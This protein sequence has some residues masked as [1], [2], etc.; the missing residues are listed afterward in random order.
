MEEGQVLRS[1][2]L[3]AEAEAAEEVEVE[4]HHTQ[5]QEQEV[6]VVG[7][8]QA[9]E[10]EV[11]AQLEEAEEE[12]A[13]LQ[14]EQPLLQLA[15][16]GEAPCYTLELEAVLGAEAEEALFHALEPCQRESR[17]HPQATAYHQHTEEEF[18][19]SQGTPVWVSLY[20]HPY[21]GEDSPYSLNP[22]SL[23]PAKHYGYSG[24]GRMGRL[25][26]REA[27]PKEEEL[28]EEELKDPPEEEEAPGVQGQKEPRVVLCLG[29]RATD[30]DQEEE[31]AGVVPGNW[32]S[33]ERNSVDHHPT[34]GQYTDQY[35]A[36]WDP[37]ADQAS[38][39]LS[40]YSDEAVRQER[41]LE[42]EWEEA[43]RCWQC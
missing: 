29:Q 25:L 7:L 43:A 38:R 39:R 32:D 35:S 37:A 26:H 3:E 41:A 14:H 12:E 4:Q 11:E 21:V 30:T 22:S 42:V 13:G 27:E 40:L 20:S 15:K 9:G 1:L 31:A 10:E 28:K 8:V 19:V 2:Q 17:S 16:E 18:H 6:A 23:V 33:W 24:G 34:S 36:H 5:E